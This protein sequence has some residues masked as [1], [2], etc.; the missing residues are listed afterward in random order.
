MMARRHAGTQT[1]TTRKTQRPEADRFQPCH[2]LSCRHRP[3]LSRISGKLVD[4]GAGRTRRSGQD[5]C[6]RGAD[7]DARSA[8]RHDGLQRNPEQ[9]RRAPAGTGSG[10]ARHAI[11][12]LT[13]PARPFSPDTERH[14]ERNE[15]G[16]ERGQRP[17]TAGETAAGGHEYAPDLT[18]H[19]PLTGVSAY[20]GF[21]GAS[22][23]EEKWRTRRDSNS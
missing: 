7:R 12:R 16:I 14:S 21:T 1:H 18:R 9:R 6:T 23:S 22:L 11:Q 3:S 8:Q 13:R 15:Q 4:G 2:A 19:R 10:G 17:V 5:R 20:A